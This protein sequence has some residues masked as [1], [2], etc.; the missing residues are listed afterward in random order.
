MRGGKLYDAT[1]GTRGRGEGLFADQMSALF[2][3]TC[4]RL[5]LNERDDE[6]STAAFR[7]RLPQKTLF[8]R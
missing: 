3:V 1:W 4:R 5:G 6:M 7:R 2:D 8:D